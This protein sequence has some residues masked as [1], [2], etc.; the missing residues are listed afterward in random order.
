M[1]SS[2]YLVSSAAQFLNGAMAC[3]DTTSCHQQKI[4]AKYEKFVDLQT[5]TKYLGEN[6]A[7]RETLLTKGK[8]YFLFF[9]RFLL[10]LS[11]KFLERRTTYQAIIV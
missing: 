3:V 4:F 5:V 1:A 9:S 2:I 6:L 7:L 8:V 10:L 11:K